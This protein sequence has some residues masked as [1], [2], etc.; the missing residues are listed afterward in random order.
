[1]TLDLRHLVE[2]VETVC[3]PLTEASAIFPFGFENIAGWQEMFSTV[4]VRNYFV[5]GNA[6]LRVTHAGLAA[7]LA[8]LPL[9]ADAGPAIETFGD[10]CSII[11]TGGGESIYVLTNGDAPHMLD[12]Y[13]DY[14]FNLPGL[15]AGRAL[16]EVEQFETSN[17][18]RRRYFQL[19]RIFYNL[20]E[21]RDVED[22]DVRS[23]SMRMMEM[24][25]TANAARKVVEDYYARVL[26]SRPAD[27]AAHRS[28][29]DF[30]SGASLPAS[31]AY[32]P[33][34]AF[35]R[36]VD[37]NYAALLAWARKR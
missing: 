37:A 27:T 17:L 23:L 2:A 16:L 22:P 26:A 33:S 21:G 10:H 4:R 29:V 3:G 15:I 5:Y 6:A 36:Q 12:A 11:R 18:S 20:A 7:K 25:A 1:M 32:V 14:L 30:G 34:P 35:S 13:G 28:L 31:P 24:D 19:F 8:A 9:L